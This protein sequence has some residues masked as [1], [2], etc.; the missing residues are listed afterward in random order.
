MDEGGKYEKASSS[1]VPGFYNHESK[2][3]TQVVYI[4]STSSE[5]KREP[6]EQHPSD[7]C[8]KK[9][10][11]YG[12]NVYRKEESR[13]NWPQRYNDPESMRAYSHDVDIDNERYSL[14]S[15]R[16]FN[17]TK[18]WGQDARGNNGD[19]ADNFSRDRSPNEAKK[20]LSDRRKHILR[21]N[22]C[23]DDRN[24]SHGVLST[25]D[26]NEDERV[27]FVDRYYSSSYI[28]ERKRREDQHYEE[29][30]RANWYKTESKLKSYEDNGRAGRKSFT[31]IRIYPH[32]KEIC[33]DRSYPYKKQEYRYG[34]APPNVTL[35]GQGCRTYEFREREARCYEDDV[36]LREPGNERME[37]KLRSHKRS[38]YDNVPEGVNAAL[39]R[40]DSEEYR[41]HA[42]E[43]KHC[44]E[45]YEVERMGN[46]EA[47]RWEKEM[48]RCK[49]MDQLQKNC[50]PERKESKCVRDEKERRGSPEDYQRIGQK[51]GYPRFAC[52]MGGSK[53][54]VLQY[55]ECF[56]G[57][58]YDYPRKCERYNELLHENENQQ[59]NGKVMDRRAMSVNSPD[60]EEKQISTQKR[61]V[62][63]GKFLT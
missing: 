59:N 19:I 13:V 55:F 3:S 42:M 1:T 50:S 14:R 2:D 4:Y 8:R 27:S 62:M 54:P 21:G 20:G 12:D 31:P 63:A 15:D 30:D 18:S 52:E 29:N 61:Y 37:E 23:R 38:K 6:A 49:S 40:R 35:M 41:G 43:G 51:D 25:R 9:D 39:Q 60:I 47:H 32:S 58:E 22:E 5:I 28:R 36:P 33:R 16:F 48:S 53:E 17:Y 11:S 57:H 56:G 10:E 34:S 45:N 24:G 46:E 7:E 26:K 44:D